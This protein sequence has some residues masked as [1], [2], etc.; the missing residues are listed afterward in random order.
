MALTS[1]QTTTSDLNPSKPSVNTLT[2]QAYNVDIT[3]NSTNNNS[4]DANK[5]QAKKLGIFQYSIMIFVMTCGGIWIL[6]ANSIIIYLFVISSK[7]LGPF[8]MS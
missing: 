2:D 3:N 7:K 6:F 5:T 8:G 4:D 1:T